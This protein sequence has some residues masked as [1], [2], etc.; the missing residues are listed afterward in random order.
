[1]VKSFRHKGLKDFFLTGKKSGVQAK[2]V[3][4]LRLILA[5]LNAA[6]APED[7]NLPGLRLH[8]LKGQKKC[9]WAVDVSGNWRIIFRLE[10]GE[11][12]DVDYLDYH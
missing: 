8:K 2:H 7:M 12:N 9:F 10:N 3:D 1:M 4:R 5:R 6:T 11:V